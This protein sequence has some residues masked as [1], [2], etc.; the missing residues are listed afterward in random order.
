MKVGKTSE[1]EI[2]SLFHFFNELSWLSDAMNN[3]EFEDVELDADFEILSKFDQKHPENFIQEIADHAK[4]LFYERVLTNCQVLLDNAAD[5]S[6]TH[7]DWK[8]ELKKLFEPKGFKDKNG[9]QFGDGD[10]LQFTHHSGYLLDTGKMLVCWDEEYGAYGYKWEHD[11][12]KCIHVFSKH[13]ELIEDVFNHCELIGDIE[14]H[15]ELL[16]VFQ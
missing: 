16:S 15:P 4:S 6:L 11:E 12:V 2:K 1:K 7:L 8:P 14:K 13:D 10:V 3:L 9:K 5:P